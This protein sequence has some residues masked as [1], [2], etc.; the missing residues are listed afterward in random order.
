[1]ST[2]ASIVDGSCL[3]VLVATPMLGGMHADIAM[4]PLGLVCHSLAGFAYCQTG[5]PGAWPGRRMAV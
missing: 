3:G 5:S 1:M 4:G 2:R